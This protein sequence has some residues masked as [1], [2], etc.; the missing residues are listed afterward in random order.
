VTQ[1]LTTHYTVSNGLITFVT[2]PANGAVITISGTFRYRCAFT[3]DTIDLI[4]Q[5]GV[6]IW[7]TNKIGF[8]SI[9]S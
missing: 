2:A 5:D 4:N 3:Q 9:K 6:D 1:T 8:E 7:K